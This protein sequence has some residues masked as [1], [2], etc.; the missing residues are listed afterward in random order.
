MLIADVDGTLVTPQKILTPAA[1]AAVR[2]LGCAGIKFT[3]IS[4]RP[5][6]GMAPVVE[7]LDIRLPF[8]AFNGGS[9]MASASTLIEAHRLAPVVAQDMLGLLAARGVDA[10]V[11]AA[12]DWRLRDPDGPKV[13]LERL[14][15][16]FGP[17]Q[18]DGFEDV[19]D[20]IDKIVGVSDDHARL[21][22]VE[23]E[24][25][26][27]FGAAAAIQRSQAY[28]LDVTHPLANKGEAVGALCRRIGVELGRTA[29]IGDMFN[30]VAM[31]TPA[32]FS[33]AMGQSPAAV[34]HSANAVTLTNT[35]D[36]FAYAVE[37][38]VLPR[39]AG[40]RD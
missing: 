2:H 31:F 15:L 18:V 30:D 29:V 21:A 38:L 26:Q 20:R 37:R 3:I 7:G 34:K 27:L 12:G 16:G 28:Y 32:A 9:L 17:T 19:I 36:G 23:S 1:V 11:Y 13:G 33:I 40:A 8:A 35:Q 24:A 25:R 4:S 14:T 22:Q 10:W 39:A 5:P 6:R